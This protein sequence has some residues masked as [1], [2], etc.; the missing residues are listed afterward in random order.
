MAE[1]ER[2]MEKK[3][4]KHGEKFDKQRCLKCKW[5]GTGIGYPARTM[6]K[7]GKMVTVMVHCNYSAYHERSC[8][9]GIGKD[10]HYDIRGE[11]WDDCLLYEEGEAEKIRPESIPEKEEE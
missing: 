4:S 1:K 8:L 5:H 10:G 2:R 7:D 9:R 6:G 11:E 3:K